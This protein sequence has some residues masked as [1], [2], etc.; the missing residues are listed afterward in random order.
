MASNSTLVR[1]GAMP[2]VA[3]PA[4]STRLSALF[5][6][7]LYQSTLGALVSNKTTRMVLLAAVPIVW[8]VMMHIG[9]IY[10]MLKIS[11]LS[12]YPI[13]HGRAP[14]FTFANYAIFFSE[15]LYFMPLI[16][17]FVDATSATAVTLLVVYPVAYYVA[18]IVQPDRR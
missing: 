16:R 5:N 15:P 7:G 4:Y 3:A 8:I 9:P 13:Q 2:A 18:K 17:S 14:T 6:S 12:N 11:L 1:G 10:Q